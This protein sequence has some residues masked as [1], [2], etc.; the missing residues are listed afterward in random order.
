MAV[1][2]HTEVV[3]RFLDE[4]GAQV[5][6]KFVASGGIPCHIADISDSARPDRYGVH[7]QRNRLE[8]LRDH[9]R[10]TTVASGLTPDTAQR[11]ADQLARAGIPCYVGG[12]TGSLV[13]DSFLS[14]RRIKE[15]GDIIAV[16]E[17]FSVGAHRIL[18]RRSP[19]AFDARDIAPLAARDPKHPS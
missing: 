1:S 8:E 2:D 18:G 10:L 4:T 5:F 13:D 6:A 14:S 9:L 19:P 17:P 15:F 12:T 16:P 7:V 11:M 3:V